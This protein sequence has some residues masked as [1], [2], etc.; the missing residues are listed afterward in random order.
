M[1]G[2]NISSCVKNNNDNLLD[3]KRAREDFLEK[4]RDFPFCFWNHCSRI[5][6]IRSELEHIPDIGIVWL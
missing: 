6:R 1:L 2:I 4:V 3:S 5:G